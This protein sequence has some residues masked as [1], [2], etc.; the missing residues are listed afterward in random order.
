MGRNRRTIN[1]ELRRGRG[2]RGYRAE[3]AYGVV[4]ERARNSRDTRLV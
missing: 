1:R 4:P 3:Q 2:L